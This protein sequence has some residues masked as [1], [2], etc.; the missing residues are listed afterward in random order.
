[1]N[2]FS[3]AAAATSLL[4]R[5]GKW[6]HRRWVS[7]A[8]SPVRA[9]AQV[10]ALALWGL[11]LAP[12]IPVLCLPPFTSSIFQTTGW[13]SSQRNNLDL[14]SH[15]QNALFVTKEE[16]F[17]VCHQTSTHTRN[18][19]GFPEPVMF[20]FLSVN[21]LKRKR[22]D[23]SKLQ[24]SKYEGDTWHTKTKLRFRMVLTEPTFCFFTRST[25][26]SCLKIKNDNK[27]STK[28][29]EKEYFDGS[30]L[31]EN[32][33]LELRNADSATKPKRCHLTRAATVRPFLQHAAYVFL[34]F[35]KVKRYC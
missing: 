26:S 21:C 12:L 27:E 16:S 7:E 32:K 19:A 28:Q 18:S 3:A 2:R 9:K 31:E 22:V 35:I 8:R 15:S 33:G 17:M 1:M 24:D 14:N 11:R 29:K 23:F 6:V 13:G 25:F 10:R 34:S 5:W 30:W 20:H 4:Q